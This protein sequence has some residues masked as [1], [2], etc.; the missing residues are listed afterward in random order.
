VYFNRDYNTSNF[1]NFSITKEDS[2]KFKLNLDYFN[3]ILS[4]NF[5]ALFMAIHSY[6]TSVAVPDFLDINSN[7]FFNTRNYRFWKL[8]Y[9]SLEWPYNTNCDY[10]NRNNL[11]HSRENCLEYCNLFNQNLS[12]KCL[13]DPS[14]KSSFSVSDRIMNKAFRHL[15]VCET[16]DKLSTLFKCEKLCKR[17]CY[18]DY[19]RYIEYIGANS[20]IGNS[21]LVQISAKN[22]PIYEYSAIPKYSFIIYMTSIGGLLSLWLGISALDL[23]A[24][25]EISIKMLKNITMKVVSIC[26]VN[27]YFYNFCS[28]ILK[29]VHY[30]NFFKKLDLKKI[31]IILS[32]ICF[33]YQLIE[34][35]L[36]FT[37]FKTTIYVKLFDKP[38]DSDYPAYSVCAYQLNKNSI[39]LLEKNLNSSNNNHSKRLKAEF[40]QMINGLNIPERNIS[41]YLILAKNEMPPFIRCAADKEENEVCIEN[42]FII[43]SFSNLGQCYTSS[44]LRYPISEKSKFTRNT[45]ILFKNFQQYYFKIRDLNPQILE[46]DQNQ[47]PSLTF[48]NDVGLK[49]SVIKVKRLPPPYDSNCFDYE[50]SKSFKSRGQC[51]NDCVFKIFLKKYDC[52]PRGSVNVLTLYDNMTLDSTFCVDNNFEDFSEDDCSDRCLKPCEEI[53]FISIQSLPNQFVDHEVNYIIYKNNIYMTFIYFISSIGGLLGLWNNVSFYDLQLIIIKICGKIFELKLIRKLSKY[54]FSAKILK[55]FDLI[56][57]FVIKINLKVKKIFT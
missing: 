47:L 6:K 48:T 57:S 3:S 26:F 12:Q 11:Y 15:K 9:K 46:H 23:R 10:Y 28:F 25:V 4:F 30:L 20:S 35:T 38:N 51:I 55:S 5:R 34:L 24:V 7:R 40:P 42:K 44:P 53:F 56:R 37:E 2:I 54:L 16:S 22:L 31:T 45:I 43:M 33:I 1:E 17:N 13:K 39:D 19:Y 36:E 29:I 21:L 18:E 27:E 8:T 49:I 14:N 41:K 52:I 50:N 32:L